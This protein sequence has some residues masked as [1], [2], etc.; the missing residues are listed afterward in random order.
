MLN[1]EENQNVPTDKPQLEEW[2]TV[3]FPRRRRNH[4]PI[5]GKIDNTNGP[6]VKVKHYNSD[7][8]KFLDPSDLPHITPSQAL[9]DGVDSG[10]VKEKAKVELNVGPPT[11]GPDRV[12]QPNKGSRKRVISNGPN[13]RGPPLNTP[14]LPQPMTRAQVLSLS[15]RIPWI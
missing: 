13:I 6:P 9:I 15:Q 5:K 10:K 3:T 14:H 8:G 4:H 1:A 2:T 12:N 11:S 7:L